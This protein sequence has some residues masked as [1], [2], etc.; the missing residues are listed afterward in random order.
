MESFNNNDAGFKF[1]AV[2]SNATFHW[3]KRDPAGV[4]ESIKKILKPGGRLAVEMGGAMN[5]IGLSI[6]YWFFA[7]ALISV[8]RSQK[9]F[10]P[11]P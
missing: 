11:C 6:Q 10:T 9:R 3:C 8:D 7:A 5:C 1:D 4:L 2:F